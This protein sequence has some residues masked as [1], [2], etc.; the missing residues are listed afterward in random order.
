MA[1]ATYTTLDRATACNAAAAVLRKAL[2]DLYDPDSDGADRAGDA[3]AWAADAVDR[4]LKGFSGLK[5]A[6]EAIRRSDTLGQFNASAYPR[7]AIAQL[8]IEAAARVIEA[9]GI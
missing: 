9:Q 5:D 3:I 7:R 1:T 8:A 6:V 2:D 4:H